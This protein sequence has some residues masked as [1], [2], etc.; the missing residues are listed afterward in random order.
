MWHLGKVLLIYIFSGMFL[1]S[2]LSIIAS[3][4]ERVATPVI[5]KALATVEKGHAEIM[6]RNHMDLMIHKRKKTVHEG[7]RSEQYSLK[8]CV[9]CHAVLG[10]DKKP[11]SVASPKHFCRTCHDYVA[12]K[13]D[14]FQCHA[15]KP[16]PSLVLDR[17][18]SSFL[19]K[20]IQEYLQ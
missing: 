18:S 8:A 15:S 6:R 7:I 10:E 13:V 20:Q 17:G 12:V 16:P 5:P 3:A 19:S 4:S 9:S 14:C 1:V 2:G 11:V